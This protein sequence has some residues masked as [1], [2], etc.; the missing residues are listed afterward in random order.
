[1][2]GDRMS[3]RVRRRPAPRFLRRRTP[4][5][6]SV[7]VS[8]RPSRVFRNVVTVTSLRYAV[9]HMGRKPQHDEN[10][11]AA[12]LDAAERTIAAEGVDALSLRDVAA[13]ADT[14]TRAIYSLFG[15]KDELLG[16]L[17][18]RAFDLLRHE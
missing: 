14:T 4:A 10:T 9:K 11:A 16:A 6:L 18:V 5:S 12:L 7:S 17:G 1:M 3:S 2:Y 8:S 15:S 13:D